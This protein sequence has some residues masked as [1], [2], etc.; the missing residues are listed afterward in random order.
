[1]DFMSPAPKVL[2]FVLAGG[3]GTRL[4]PLTA[5]QCKPAVPFQRRYRLVDFVLANLVN[6]RI[7]PIF[8]LAQYK[9][10]PLIEHVR[11]AWDSPG[12]P[13]RTLLPP[14]GSG[15][16]LGTADAVFQQLDLVRRL[17][18]DIVAV[19]GADH[20]YRM[21]VG[22]MVAFHLRSKADASVATVPVRLSECPNFGVVETAADHRIRGF[23][24]KPPAARPMPGSTTH[25]LASMGNYLFDA[26]VLV[27]QLE[28]MNARGETDFGRHVLPAMLE[29][30]RVVAYDFATNTVPG[31]KPWEEPAYWRDVGT[32]E[33]YDQAHSDSAGAR[34]KFELVNRR[35]PIPS[36][37]PEGDIIVPADARP[38]TATEAQLR[39]AL[40][41][42]ARTHI[43]RVAST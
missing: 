8:L 23:S 17:R 36:R 16:Y 5:H 27:R 39:R 43:G 20:V 38:P 21:D 28:Q 30:Q 26:E 42:E 25:A 41:H 3:E 4:Q 37:V 19:F 10:V 18:P 7:S 13:I 15:G 1:M 11:R 32:L 40:H 31:T 14:A 22:Q 12:H 2:A 29:T 6:S 34:P 33:A 24:E 9:P 35:W